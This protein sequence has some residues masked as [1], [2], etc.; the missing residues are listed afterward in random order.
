MVEAMIN[1]FVWD[2]ILHHVGMSWIFFYNKEMKCENDE[3]IYNNWLNKVP[4]NNTDIC[5]KLYGKL[6]EDYISQ[7][8]TYI[9]H[10]MCS[11]VT[12]D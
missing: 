3:S 11:I 7:E 10:L 8:R 1:K 9:Y 6:F 5:L 4:W 2:A 12:H